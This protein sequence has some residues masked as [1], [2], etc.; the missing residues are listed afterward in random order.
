MKSYYTMKQSKPKSRWLEITSVILGCLVLSTLIVV[1]LVF[2]AQT[3]DE[4]FN[5][6]IHQLYA[7]IVTLILAVV[8]WILWRMKK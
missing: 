1:G 8:F 5:N 4:Y 2:S 3:I 6:P 7:I